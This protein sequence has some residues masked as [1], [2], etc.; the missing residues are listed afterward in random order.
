MHGLIELLNQEQK[1]KALSTI[2][3]SDPSTWPFKYRNLSEAP[4]KHATVLRMIRAPEMSVSQICDAARITKPLLMK[5]VHHP[6]NKKFL[7]TYNNGTVGGL[8][9]HVTLE[10]LVKEGL[11]VQKRVMH[12]MNR[13]MD[14]VDKNPELLKE[15][16]PIIRT[17]HQIVT[18]AMNRNPTGELSH[19]KPPEERKEI[20]HLTAE[21]IQA[22]TKAA[23]AMRDNAEPIEAEF[24]EVKE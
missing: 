3:D 6:P 13:L 16:N 15:Y 22:I 12:N 23:K 8:Q 24:E 10:D 5:I 18:D 20:K 9:H 1:G 11:K 17:V 2:V 21:D 7:E 19:R 4:A 14:R